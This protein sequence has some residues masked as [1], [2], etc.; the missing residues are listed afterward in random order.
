VD[1]VQGLKNAKHRAH[2]ARLQALH[3]KRVLGARIF[4][5]A[6]RI[7]P[8]E[9]VP[10]RYGDAFF[11][12]SDP[13][14]LLQPE[15]V[16]ERLWLIWTGENEMSSDRK[17]RLREI[18]EK[19]SDIEVTL[20]TPRNLGDFEVHNSPINPAYEHLSLVHRSDYLRCYLLHHHG[21]GY[22]DIKTPRISISETF[23]AFRDPNIWL[24]T[25]SEPLTILTAWMEGPINR[26]LNVHRRWVPGQASMVSRPRTPITSEWY[27]ELERRIDANA[28]RLAAEPGGVYGQGVPGGAPP[29]NP[30][31]PFHWA[32]LLSR[33]YHPLGLK[34]RDH[35]YYE[36][37]MFPSLSN[38]R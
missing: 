2:I 15:S 14:I 7:R 24:T 6:D 31:Y 37:R 12:Q 21:G 13:K 18:Y 28:D 22:I 8:F 20:V 30:S 33:I 11:A 38:Y 26:D 35:V 23:D 32:D 17:D 1:L 19:N 3:K 29:S 36:E 9:W 27:T 10:E 25:Y 34:Y 16:P 5:I 4:D